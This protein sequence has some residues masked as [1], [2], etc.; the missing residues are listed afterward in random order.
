[1][2]KDDVIRLDIKQ[3]KSEKDCPDY[4]I[5][6]DKINK[7]CQFQFF[8][9][10][11]TC[12]TVDGEGY[13]QFDN[14]KYKA[15]TCKLSG[16]CT[17]GNATSCTS[18]SECLSNKC[19]NNNCYVNEASPVTECGVYHRYTSLTFSYRTTMYCDKA[20][21]EPC[22]SDND[23]F[24]NSCVYSS[25]NNVT[26]SFCSENITKDLT[27][28]KRNHLLNLALDIF[29]IL[30]I[31]A[32]FIFFYRRYNNSKKEN[33][34]TNNENDNDNTNNEDNNNDSS[35]NVVDNDNDNNSN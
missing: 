31:L 3:Y 14:T 6:Y 13:V 7:F 1:M 19:Y 17:H 2:N 28:A 33:N 18:D 23:C 35:I 8:C 25:Q 22:G 21:N 32:I 30:L 24:S 29:I 12:T 27:K 20:E 9:R 4:S 10:N 15:Y 26:G 11:E 34:N 16:I 5:G